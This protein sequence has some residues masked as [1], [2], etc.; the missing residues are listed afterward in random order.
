M[1]IS[2]F[3]HHVRDAANQ[4]NMSLEE[5]FDYVKSLGIDYLEIDAADFKEGAEEFYELMTKHGLKASNICLL[6]H[7]ENDPEDM[8]DDLQIR[9][10]KAMHC[11]KIMPIPGLYTS[12]EKP[13]AELANMLKGFQTIAA[14]AQAEGLKVCMEDY[15]HTL[16]PIATM[17]GMKYFVDNIPGLKIA[18][19]TGNFRFS[20]EDALDAY[21]LLGDG[22]IHMHLKDRSYKECPGDT[23]TA[24]DGV[25]L[26]PC[27]VG[28]GDMPMKEIIE[29]ELK[30]GYDGIFTIEFYGAADMKACIED[31]VKFLNTIA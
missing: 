11:D 15:D 14:K 31:S 8:M 22:I 27:A 9:V 2:V 4:N 26:Y 12:E 17:G 3:F 7:W 23:K 5:M 6:H 16:S 20:A 24:T 13:A 21:D 18:F 30:K 19:D 1:K 29:K 28:A 10:A 25:V